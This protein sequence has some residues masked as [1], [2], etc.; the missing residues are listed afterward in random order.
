ML[1]TVALSTNKT[2]AQWLLAELEPKVELKKAN[3]IDPFE[4]Q[5]KHPLV[6]HMSDWCDLLRV[7][8]TDSRDGTGETGDCQSDSEQVT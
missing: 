5:R 3:L 6:E 7:I 4:T 8:E 1:Q 2:A